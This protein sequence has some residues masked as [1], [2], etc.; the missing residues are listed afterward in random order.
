MTRHETTWARNRRASFDN[1]S[2][3]S[4]WRFRAMRTTMPLRRLTHLDDLKLLVGQEVAVSD[5]LPLTQ[6]TI[7][8]FAQ[9]TRDSQW[10]HLD[11]RRA[12][13]ESPYQTTIAHG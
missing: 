12:A 8:A 5:W 9:V 4:A 1:A 3:N 6:E 11:P 2:K 7:G 13:A 10:I